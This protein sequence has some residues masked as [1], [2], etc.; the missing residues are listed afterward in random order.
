M[1]CILGAGGVEECYGLRS[2]RSC[3]GVFFPSV[4]N[5]LVLNSQGI[6]KTLVTSNG[7]CVKLQDA[8][9]LPLNFM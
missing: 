3:G 6:V 9:V 4:L 5:V 1:S 7:Y 8:S 2:S